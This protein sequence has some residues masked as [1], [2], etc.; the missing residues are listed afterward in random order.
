MAA[1]GTAN[2]QA[3]G[4]IM[5]CPYSCR[6][7]HPQWRAGPMAATGTAYSQAKGKAIAATSFDARRT[8]DTIQSSLLQPSNSQVKGK[9]I[10]ATSLYTRRTEDTMQSSL[11]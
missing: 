3:K 8:E 6:G 10:A 11:L 1:T 5:C 7:Q 4:K 9:S 2:S